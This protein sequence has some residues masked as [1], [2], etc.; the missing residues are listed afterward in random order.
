MIREQYGF[1]TYSIRDRHSLVLR[2]GTGD[3]AILFHCLASFEF[4]KLLS[5]WSHWCYPAKIVQKEAKCKCIHN[6]SLSARI[7]FTT[8]NH[9]FPNPLA[10]VSS[11]PKRRIGACPYR[12]YDRHQ[13]LVY[14]L[15][16]EGLLVLVIIAF[17]IP[18]D[19][20]PAPG[21]DFPYYVIMFLPNKTGI[22]I[23][24]VSSSH[25]R[26]TTCQ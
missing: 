9:P 3:T 17:L 1:D 12:L 23:F 15:N 2:W 22:S 11:F 19:A 14:A 26:E 21:I 18:K 25:S 8:I 4:Q 6:H 16:A 10:S 5:C 24:V 7:Q 20:L 13:F